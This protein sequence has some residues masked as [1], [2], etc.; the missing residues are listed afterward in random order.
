M[1]EV[2]RRRRPGAQPKESYVLTVEQVAALE[3]LAEPVSVARVAAILGQSESSI[4]NAIYDGRLRAVEYVWDER[5]MY[6]LQGKDVL[7][8]ARSRPYRRKRKKE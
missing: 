5:T 6:K 4:Y 7:E 8:Y 3:S 2:R 1:E